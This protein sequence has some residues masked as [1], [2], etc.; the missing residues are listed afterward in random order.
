MRGTP[1]LVI[2][3][4]LVILGAIILG[5]GHLTYWHRDTVVDVGPVSVTAAHQKEAPLAPI[6]GGV[7]LAG[8]VAL[9][10]LGSRKA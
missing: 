5:S 2:G 6:F 4:I 1:L 9:I 10:V 8:G 7:A 3:V